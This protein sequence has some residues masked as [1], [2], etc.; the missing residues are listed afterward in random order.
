M[1]LLFDRTYGNNTQSKTVLVLNT[2]PNAD[3]VRK[4]EIEVV[5]AIFMDILNTKIVRFILLVLMFVISMMFL[6][7]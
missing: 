3:H 6:I 4:N 2:K 1:I 7:I 5:F